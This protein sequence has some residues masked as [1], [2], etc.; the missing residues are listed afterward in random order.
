MFDGAPGPK[1]PPQMD[2]PDD[3]PEVSAAQARFESC[4]WRSRD[5]GPPPHCTHRDVLPMAGTQGFTAEAWCGDC[6]FYKLR[7]TPRRYS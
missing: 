3:R 7:R 2:A 4:R 1:L 5:E 6:P